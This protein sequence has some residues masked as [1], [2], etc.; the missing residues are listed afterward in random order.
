MASA[1]VITATTSR[2][3]PPWP[4]PPAVHA[5]VGVHLCAGA[6]ALRA[7]GASIG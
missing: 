5:T 7:A 4:R 6:A 2:P 3:A 1:L